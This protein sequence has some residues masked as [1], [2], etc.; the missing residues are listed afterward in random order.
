M[1]T[2]ELGSIERAEEKAK[3]KQGVTNT[4]GPT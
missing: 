1:V 3:E 4:A 2:E